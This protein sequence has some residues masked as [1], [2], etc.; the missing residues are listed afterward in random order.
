M[1]LCD[2]K[3]TAGVGPVGFFISIKSKGYYT[4]GKQI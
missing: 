2:E 3:A 4:G 1:Y